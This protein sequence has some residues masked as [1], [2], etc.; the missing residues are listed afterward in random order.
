MA[1]DWW[2]PMVRLP[3][4]AL[5]TR[6]RQALVRLRSDRR[7][8]GL[9]RSIHISLMRTIAKNL[10]LRI[11]WINRRKFSGDPVVPEIPG[12]SVRQLTQEDYQAANA[13]PALE[14]DEKFTTQALSRSHFCVGAFHNERLVSYVWRAF[15]ATPINERFLLKFEKPNRYGYKALTLPEHRGKRLQNPI[16]LFSDDLCFRMGFTYAISFIETHNYGSIRSDARRG[17][18]HI[19]WIAWIDR[20][21]LPFSF[22]SKGA[23]AIGVNLLRQNVKSRSLSQGPD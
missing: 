9:A 7:Q 1:C 6:F 23:R 15:S 3:T 22:T 8:W 13:D 4:D 2:M 19:G 11:A 16:T 12:Y 5:I 18:K 21:R 17:N 20:D 14:M 10:G